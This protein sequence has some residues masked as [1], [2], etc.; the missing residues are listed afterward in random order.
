[1]LHSFM[2]HEHPSR[3]IAEMA[4]TEATT[5][6]THKSEKITESHART[7]LKTF[8]WRILATTTTVVIAYLVFGDVSNALKVGGIEFFA[9][10]IIYYM[11]ERAW[12][13]LPRGSVRGWFG[14]KNQPKPT[15]PTD[16]RWDTP[17]TVRFHYDRCDNYSDTPK[18]Q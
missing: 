9:K 8:S 15:S 16:P 11:H 5:D 3:G 17:A 1:M 12:Q 6:K 14:K 13:L 10:M 7:L 18:G 2:K 4:K